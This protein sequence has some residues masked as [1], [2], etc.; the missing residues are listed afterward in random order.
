MSVAVDATLLIY[1]SD[2]GIAR[3]NRDALAS[4]ARDLGCAGSDGVVRLG[5]AWRDRRR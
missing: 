4:R 5:S 3:T 2:R 1:A